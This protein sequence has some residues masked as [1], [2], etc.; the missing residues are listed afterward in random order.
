MIILKL[1]WNSR[2][3]TRKRSIAKRLFKGEAYRPYRLRYKRCAFTLVELAVVMAIIAIIVSMVAVN[4]RQ[5]VNR[6]RLEN[7]FEQIDLL[8][9]RVRRW[10]KTNN[11]PA[12]IN[13]DLDRGIFTAEQE[14]GGKFPLPN[15]KT[16]DGMKLKELRIMG[17]NRFG[18]DTKI[19]YTSQGIAPCW[20]YSIVHSGN[21]EQYR[22]IIGTTGQSLTM[23]SEEE[24]KQLERLYENE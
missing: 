2:S 23:V 15:V 22:L 9:Q 1:F 8:D 5:P 6:A 3:W 24:L 18:K 11:I 20:A 19:P 21:C 10:T 16:P 7:F 13:V 12:R 17:E 4:Y 14:N